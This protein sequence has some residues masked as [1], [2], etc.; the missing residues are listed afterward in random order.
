MLLRRV[1]HS[2]AVRSGRGGRD[3]IP[4]NMRAC[5]S[6]RATI[7]AI[8]CTGTV[9][10]PM[11]LSARVGVRQGGWW[12]ARGGTMNRAEFLRRLGAVI[13]TRWMI[14]ADGA[15]SNTDGGGLAP[16]TLPER[17]LGRT[18]VMLPI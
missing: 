18:G 12:M 8:R 11:V 10:A 5:S 17:R 1:R 4:G 3:G 13:G 15:P 9:S 14:G 16:G 6:V 2:L 7:V